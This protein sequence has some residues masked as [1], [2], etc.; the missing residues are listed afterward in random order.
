MY[1]C[2]KIP[3]PLGMTALLEQLLVPHPVKKLDVLYEIQVPI[4][5]FTTAQY[6]NLS[7]ARL[8]KSKPFHHMNTSLM[9]VFQLPLHHALYVVQSSSQY[10]DRNTNVMPKNTNTIFFYLSLIYVLPR[11]ESLQSP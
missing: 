7:T 3:S 6:M 8:I 10:P 9:A 5:K 2:A 11:F 4:A 1:F